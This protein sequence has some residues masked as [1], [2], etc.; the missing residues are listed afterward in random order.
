VADDKQRWKSLQDQIAEMLELGIP[1]TKI[2]ERLNISRETVRN[3]E[4]RIKDQN[5]DNDNEPHIQ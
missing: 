1:K 3:Y 4:K 5:K 2:A